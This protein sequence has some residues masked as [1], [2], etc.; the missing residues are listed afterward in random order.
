MISDLNNN[1]S[2]PGVKIP[3]YNNYSATKDGRIWSIRGKKF[4]KTHKYNGYHQL[5]LGKNSKMERVHRLIAI[6]YLGAPISKDY[7]VNHIDKNKN[8]N[9]V[10]NLEWV[11]PQKNMEHSHAK[12]YSFISP[13]NEKITVYNLTKFCKENNLSTSHMV[14]V[15]N[16]RIHYKSH[17]GWKQACI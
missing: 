12:T 11:T 2:Y 1:Q 9:H 6:T 5:R 16:G 4:L 13:L 17:K 3:N 10:D 14:G 15:A 8:N 7:E